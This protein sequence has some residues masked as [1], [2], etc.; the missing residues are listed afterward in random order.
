MIKSSQILLFLILIFFGCTKKTFFDQSVISSKDSLKAYLSLAN[1]INLTFDLKQKY[2]QKALDIIL[3][4]DND[5][6]NRV[7]LFKVANRYY[8]MNDLKSY[9]EISK[10]ILKRSISS[11]DSVSTAKAYTYLGD[12]Y[13]SQAISDS[14][15][16]SL[17][18][19]EKLYVRIND[20]YN[21]AKTFLSKASLQYN[22]GD[23]FESEIAV[24]KA[25]SI[26]KRQKNVS[27]QL[28]ECYNLL[29]ILYSDREEYDKSLEFHN[30][31]L[32]VL[33]DKT[34]P[35]ELQL[36]ATS[37]NNIGFVYIS[38]RKYGKAKIYFQK[39][40]EE[41]NLFK[42]KIVLY[43]MLVD[44]LAYSRFKLKESNGLPDLFFKSLKIRDSLG[45]KSGIVSNKIHLSEY[46]AFKK[47]TFRAIQ[48]SKQALIL[49]RTSSKLNNTLEALQQLAI[50][51]IKNASGYSREYI[52]L[53]DKMLKSERNMGEKFSRIEYETNEIKDQNSNLQ[54]KNKTL[55]YI[56]SICT[57]IG[58][59]FYVYKTQQAKNRELL[60]KQ[61][62]QIANEDIY[63]LMISQQ[64]DIE[65]TRIR[66]KKK[67][68]QD[69]HDG[70][71]GRMFGVRISLD[72]LDKVD[73]ADAAPKRKKYLTELKN[74]E[75]DIRE[76]SH[77]LNREKSELINNFIAI[78]NNLFED[79][80]NTYD[81]KLITSFDSNIKWDLVSNTVK[82]NLYRIV[83]EALQNCNKYAD[84]NTIIIE[85]KSEIDHL[86]VSIYDDGVGFN[87]KKTKNG[88]GLHNI[89]YRAAECKGTV[90]IKSAKGEGT[91]LV[92]KIPIDQKINLHNT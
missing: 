10:L 78:L 50:V 81:S 52:R 25:L 77:D 12:Y 7:N 9:R 44:N 8:N 42:E 41:N 43:A 17:F 34:I 91:L 19:A 79:Q 39:G 36:K 86:V 58:L 24:F 69:L 20:Q 26:L 64:N 22:H 87:T 29:G 16:M 74:I 65:L 48:F 27:D 30:K 85:F 57:L 53:N 70:V 80:Q 75:Q 71:L 3:N 13:S 18:K 49:S 54:E 92:I 2:N 45:L 82:I 46:Y 32:D 37:L 62:Q 23:F 35:A 68:A 47:D 38:M 60:F 56:F 11:K 14:A 55:I 63:N 28:Y 88:I 21:L 67:V 66:E 6:I 84:A 59:F 89:Q 61:Q 72:S 31:A 4:Q 40:L 90:A 73:E 76:I 83:Q 15:F 33:T 51:D 1:D 5:S